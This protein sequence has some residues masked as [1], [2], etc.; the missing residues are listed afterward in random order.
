MFWVQSTFDHGWGTG[1]VSGGNVRPERR[2]QA[3][4]WGMLRG[5]YRGGS[6]SALKVREQTND[7]SAPSCRTG[8][9]QWVD[10]TGPEIRRLVKDCALVL[11]SPNLV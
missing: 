11:T 1:R 8:G 9:P 4:L 10:D 6:Y 5:V 3:Q 7:V 2:V